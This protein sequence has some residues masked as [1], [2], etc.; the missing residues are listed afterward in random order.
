MKSIMLTDVRE[1]VKQKTKVREEWSTIEAR[2][3]KQRTWRKVATAVAKGMRDHNA[4]FNKSILESIPASWVVR[5]DGRVAVQED[6][7]EEEKEGQEDAVCMCCFDGSSLEGNRIMFCDGCNAAVH[8]A[9]YGVQDI[10]EGDFFCDRCRAVQMMAD[11]EQDD[12]EAES[13]FDPNNARDAIKCCFCPMYHGGLKPTTDG[14]WVHLCCAIW[15]GNSSILDLAEMSPVDVSAVPVQVYREKECYDDRRRGRSGEKADIF[16]IS[17]DSHNDGLGQSTGNVN[18]RRSSLSEGISESVVVKAGYE[19][20]HT[21][22]VRRVRVGE[23]EGEW[24]DEDD[25]TNER[26]MFCDAYGG[27]VVRCSGCDT[28]TDTDVGV[29]SGSVPSSSSSSSSRKGMCACVFHP[30]CAWF[31]GVHIKT[32]I[33]DPT[34]QV[35]D[36]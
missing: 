10:P 7:E 24:V 29:D 4:D 5:V 12:D 14:R 23:E 11:E 1:K 25:V 13:Y 35:H 18:R 28:H 27:F 21:N 17:N 36:L 8:Q 33:T 20:N 19:V 30:L 32:R 15:S 3:L 2:Y 34:F 6:A 16:T 22:N 26:C 9:C 31:Q